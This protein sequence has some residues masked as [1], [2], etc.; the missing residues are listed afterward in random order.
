MPTTKHL[1]RIN[2]VIAWGVSQALQH[3]TLADLSS[4][5]ENPPSAPGGSSKTQKSPPKTPKAAK[6]PKAAKVRGKKTNL[7][8]RYKPSTVKVVRFLSRVR[9]ITHSPLIQADRVTR[10]N[11]AFKSL[12]AVAQ[13]RVLDIINQNHPDWFTKVPGLSLSA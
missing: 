12:P 2:E 5:M 10:A 7:E 8:K 11:D 13:R 9:A 3:L 4:L 6:E 1:N